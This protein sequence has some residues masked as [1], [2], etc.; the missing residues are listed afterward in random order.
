METYIIQ[1]AQNTK[2]KKKKAK[3]IKGNWLVLSDHNFK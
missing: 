2:K 1:F 3:N